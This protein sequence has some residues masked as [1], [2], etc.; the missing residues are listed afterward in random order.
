MK[1]LIDKKERI[2]QT[3]IKKYAPRIV[4][5]FSWPWPVT[6]LPRIFHRESRLW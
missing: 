4:R 6:G 1:Q 3:D 2:K 5:V